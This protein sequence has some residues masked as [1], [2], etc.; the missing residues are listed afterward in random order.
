MDIRVDRAGAWEFILPSV[1]G[2]NPVQA[3]QVKKNN[4]IKKINLIISSQWIGVFNPS[5]MIDD[6]GNLLV[7][8]NDGGY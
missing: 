5:I 3:P 7:V 6:Q 4:S 2:S 8:S 1:P